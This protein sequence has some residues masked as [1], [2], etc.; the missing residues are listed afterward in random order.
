[1]PL[2]VRVSG[3]RRPSRWHGGAVACIEWRR[4]PAV[5]REPYSRETEYGEK[6]C[7][8]GPPCRVRQRVWA[9]ALDLLKGKHTV[10][11]HYI[12]HTGDTILVLS[13]V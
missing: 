10:Q 2:L 11:I 9:I 6:T 4:S 13:L 5:Q 8:V 1:M 3:V 7:K 12:E